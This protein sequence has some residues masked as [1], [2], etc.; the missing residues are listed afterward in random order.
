MALFGVKQ[1]SM[2]TRNS[3]EANFPQGISV[4][5]DPIEASLPSVD[6]VLVHGLSGD[7][8][9]TWRHKENG[10][11]WP[12]DFLPLDIPNSRVLTFGYNPRPLTVSKSGLLHLA[13]TLLTQLDHLRADTRTACTQ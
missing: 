6:I 7:C 4:V 5:F 3:K 12:R 9:A 2:P 1:K 11:F 13:E 10:A 8:D